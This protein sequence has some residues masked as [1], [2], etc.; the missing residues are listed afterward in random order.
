VRWLSREDE[1]GIKRRREELR[2]DEGGIREDEAEIK[3]K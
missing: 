1:G 2:K 3:R